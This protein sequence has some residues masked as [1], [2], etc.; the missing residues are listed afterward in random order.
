MAKD[1]HQKVLFVQK[2]DNS[3]LETESL[4]CIKD[5]DFYMVDNIPFIAKRIALGDIIKAEYDEDEKAYYFDDFVAISGNS[6]I[7]LYFDNIDI[8]EGVRKELESFGCESEAF[9]GRKIVAVNIPKD[10]NYK[11]IKDYLE[12]GEHENKWEYE[13]ACLSHTY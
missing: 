11:P 7:R 2:K 5:G 6:T 3:E 1:V 13:E 9:L 4:W 12:K 8:I 10:V